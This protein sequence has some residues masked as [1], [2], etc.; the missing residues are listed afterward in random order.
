VKADVIAQVRGMLD[1]L[2]SKNT[3]MRT[4]GSIATLRTSAWFKGFHWERLLSKQIKA[5]FVPKIAGL[6]D[7]VSKALKKNQSVAKVIA[8]STIVE[9]SQ[10]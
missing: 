8:V 7:D 1:I 6:E 5:P 4:S 10:G 9:G 2:L 3:A